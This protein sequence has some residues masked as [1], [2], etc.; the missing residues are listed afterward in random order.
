MKNLPIIITTGIMKMM[1]SIWQ[2]LLTEAHLFFHCPMTCVHVFSAPLSGGTLTL[3]VPLWMSGEPWDARVKC[4][5]VRP[6]RCPAELRSAASDDVNR[7]AVRRLAS[8][9]WVMKERMVRDIN[10]TC[11]QN[12]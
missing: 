4:R 2:N 5:R 11:R 3:H 7:N 10:I 6:R 1:K 12:L 8:V 9:L